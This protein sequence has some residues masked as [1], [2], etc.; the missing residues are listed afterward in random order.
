M[1]GELHQQM[2]KCLIEHFK[3]LNCSNIKAAYEGYERPPEIGG[4]IPDV[5]SESEHGVYIGEA[6][7]LEDLS[8]EHTSCQLKEFTGA[9]TVILCVPDECKCTM[10]A[11]CELAKACELGNLYCDGKVFKILY[12]PSLELIDLNP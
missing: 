10:D 4:F 5:Y 12:Y 8:N 3:L 11:A 1:P 9:G 6:K 7:T 2:V